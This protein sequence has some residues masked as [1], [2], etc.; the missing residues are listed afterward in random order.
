MTAKVE[1]KYLEMDQKVCNVLRCRRMYWRE[2]LG[3]EEHIS[4]G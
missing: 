2:C 3:A 1:Q 4:S